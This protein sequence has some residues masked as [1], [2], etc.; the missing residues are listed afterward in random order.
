MGQANLPGKLA[1]RFRKNA[2]RCLSAN[3]SVIQRILHHIPDPFHLRAHLL[4]G[5]SGLH[6][7]LRWLQ[8]RLQKARERYQHPDRKRPLYHIIHT[9]RKHTYIDQNGDR[10]DHT[11]KA[12]V[13]HAVTHSVPI[14]SRLIARP[15]RK[16]TG[17]RAACLKGFDL[18]DPSNDGRGLPALIAHQ[19]PRDIN[20]FGGNHPRQKEIA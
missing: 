6:D 16:E 8:K 1:D 15:F 19:R 2:V 10:P 4:N 13:Q 5:L 7:R 12:G 9:N 11:A 3:K 18:P 20:A 14:D 17:L